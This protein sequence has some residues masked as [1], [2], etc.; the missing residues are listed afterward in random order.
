M[1]GL[2]AFQGNSTLER[3]KHQ[4]LRYGSIPTREGDRLNLNPVA[5]RLMPTLHLD[6][7]NISTTITTTWS[8]YIY[9][10]SLK[11]LNMPVMFLYY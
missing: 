1:I 11:A 7:N 8:V 9:T 6:N 3:V 4:C 10:M 2:C 5:I